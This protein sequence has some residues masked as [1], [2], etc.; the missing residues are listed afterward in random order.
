MALAKNTLKIYSMEELKMTNNE[1][2]NVYSNVYGAGKTTQSNGQGKSVAKAVLSAVAFIALTAGFAL[3][4]HFITTYEIT[5]EWAVA[6]YGSGL[7]LY[8]FF[9]AGVLELFDDYA[10]GYLTPVFA[11]MPIN[12]L[13][14]IV[15]TEFIES[16]VAFGSACIVAFIIGVVSVI[17]L[18][19]SSLL[20]NAVS[21]SEYGVLGTV[22]GIIS[23][24][25]NALTNVATLA[26]T[27]STLT[28]ST[29]FALRYISLMNELFA[30][31][32][33]FEIYE[34]IAWGAIICEAILLV[35]FLLV[36]GLT[37]MNFVTDII[38][39]F[40]GSEED[41]PKFG[42]KISMVLLAIAPLFLQSLVFWGIFLVIF[43]IV[44]FLVVE[45]VRLLC[46]FL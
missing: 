19:L 29:G 35:A 45:F 27:F 26:I 33:E 14:G 28:I 24:I 3:L 16:Y 10:M 37:I 17:Y 7:T 11:E 20:F 43:A 22:T 25:M 41:G 18:Q 6:K 44:V 40:D 8:E 1:T 2:V 5:S 32:I 31:V 36:A 30:D 15:T 21:Q 23:K 42:E 4:V 39:I 38:S 12:A 13:K 46:I 34:V 9:R